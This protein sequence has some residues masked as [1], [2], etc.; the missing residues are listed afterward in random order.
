MSLPATLSSYTLIWSHLLTF[1]VYQLWSLC[2]SRKGTMSVSPDTSLSCY[3]CVYRVCGRGSCWR[4]C[5][6]SLGRI[7]DSS[8]SLLSARNSWTSWETSS[9]PWPSPASSG[10][11][12]HSCFWHVPGLAPTCQGSS[13]TRELGGRCIVLR[14]HKP[15]SL[16]GHTLCPRPGMTPK[17]GSLSLRYR[18]SCGP[19]VGTGA[20]PCCPGSAAISWAFVQLG[21]KV[22]IG[23]WPGRCCAASTLMSEPFVRAWAWEP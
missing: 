17:G 19:G 8:A 10:A 3:S 16:G 23:S 9:L 7:F 14:Q 21:P 2:Q 15:S 12:L 4:N 5:C 20:L 1:W 6:Q 13:G 22:D 11:G 18:P